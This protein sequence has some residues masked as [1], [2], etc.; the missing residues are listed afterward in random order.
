MGALKVSWAQ[1]QIAR[2]VAALA[3]AALTILCTSSEICAA[4]EKLEDKIAAHLDALYENIPYVIKWKFQPKIRIFTDDSSSVSALISDLNI[5]QAITR[6]PEDEGA[7]R[8]DAPIVAAL[9]I[10]KDP[11]QLIG[12]SEVRRLFRADSQSPSQ[13]SGSFRALKTGG[14]FL[15]R[16]NV[17][18]TFEIDYVAMAASTASLRAQVGRDLTLEMALTLF[19]LVRQSDVITPS[20]LN[21]DKGSLSGI[22]TLP[23][24]DDAFL[25]ALYSE[26]VRNGTKYEEAR[27][28]LVK[29]MS[30]LMLKR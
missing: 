27:G 26:E 23:P 15:R 11:V 16:T 6:L 13:F 25:R 28:T 3:V 19:A 20:L 21:K 8:D 1:V 29:L 14:G 24:V 10:Y 2:R 4:A 12:D 17:L 18:T 5:V 22:R 9:F 30:S 7:V